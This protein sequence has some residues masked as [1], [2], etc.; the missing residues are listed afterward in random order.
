MRPEGNFVVCVVPPIKRDNFEA[1]ANL[2]AVGHLPFNPI[3]QEIIKT[4]DFLLWFN[5]PS[6]ARL[7][8][9]DLVFKVDEECFAVAVIDEIAPIT[10]C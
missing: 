7:V 2:S 3:V 9:D 8:V 5:G 10:K 6:G 4:H 1:A